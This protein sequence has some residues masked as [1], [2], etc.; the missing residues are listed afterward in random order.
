[1]TSTQNFSKISRLAVSVGT[2]LF[3]AALF[4]SVDMAQAASGDA[5]SIE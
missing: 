3:V 1:M 5:A 2:S 4:L